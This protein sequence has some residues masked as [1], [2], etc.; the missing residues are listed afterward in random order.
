MYS[1]DSAVDAFLLL[2]TLT[3]ACLPARAAFRWRRGWT[4]ALGLLAALGTFTVRA[5]SPAILWSTNIGARVFAVDAQTNVYANVGG[6]V[7]K[8]SAAGVPLQTNAFCPL[9]GI[10][11]RDPAGNI[12]FAGDISSLQDFGG[13]SLGP[14]GSC[15]LAKY[16]SGGSLAWA[17]SFGAG[18]NVT[19]MVLDGQGNAFVGRKLRTKYDCFLYAC[20]FEPT[21][22]NTWEAWLGGS[23]C[24]SGNVTLGVASQTN[25]YGMAYYYGEPFGHYKNTARFASDGTHTW[26]AVGSERSGVDMSDRPAGNAHGLVYGVLPAGGLAQFTADGDVIWRTPATPTILMTLATDWLGGVYVS[27]AYTTI[28]RYDSEGKLLWRTNCPTACKALVTDQYG[29]TFGTFLA[30]DSGYLDGTVVRFAAEPA[31]FP[32]IT[33]PP[34]NLTLLVGESA[35]LSV[36]VAGSAPFGYSW[37]LNG[38]DVP[39][40][41]N[42]M[43]ALNTATPAL[44]GAYTVAITNAA[45]AITSAPAL[46]RVKSVQLYAGG[47]MLTNGTY[48]FATPPAL[49][50]RS[51]FPGGSAFYTLD[52]SPPSFASTP[53]TGPFTLQQNATVRAIGYSADFSQSEEADSVNATLLVNH[54][55]SVVAAAGGGSVTLDPP[56]GT[57]LSSSVIT[58][59]AVPATGWSFL[60]WTGDAVGSNPGIGISMERDKTIRAVFGTTLGST[61]AGS[62]QVLLDPPGGVYPYGATVRL[63]A[64]PVAGNYFGVWGNAASGNGN[65][66]SF[67]VTNANPTVS[68]IFGATPAGQAALTVQVTGQGRVDAVPQANAYTLNQAVT[69]TA[70]PDAGQSFLN[71]SGDA[72]GTQNPLP[73]TMSTAKGITANFTTRPSL[74]AS[75]AGLEGLTSEGFR[76]TL[77]S[78]PAS[79][80]AILAS[81]NLNFW[82]NV[83]RV[84]NTY[85]ETQIT[86]RSAVGAPMKFYK[87]T[88]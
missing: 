11:H 64:V 44:A 72:S 40:G 25:V 55:L 83:G 35:S 50:V 17:K 20:K 7:V 49:T 75:Q 38:N 36:G 43:L 15:F 29:N 34:V 56:G 27:E 8:L 28:A 24:L 5:Q 74:R 45:G 85:G 26:F 86:D 19:D 12:F 54:T 58:A 39:G 30:S 79:V 4:V 59:T 63:T 68:S 37:R 48:V 21:G 52:G 66:L 61:V 71:W 67:T 88:P 16:T 23:G 80:Y 1:A 62:G 22:T 81:T 76:L 53:Y 10:A 14:V 87:A 9:P 6:S 47:Q 57:Y 77:L 41:T 32:V 60:Y 70:V 51:V 2:A 69:L 42:A 73:V 33:N 13:V 31:Q 78:E 65:P 46:L 84:T 3:T 18:C 82:E